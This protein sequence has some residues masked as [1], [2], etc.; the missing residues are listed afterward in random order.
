MSR[1]HVR[2]RPP[3]AKATPGALWA[4]S[5]TAGTGNSHFRA[6]A[7]DSGGNVYAAGDIIGL[8]TFGF[9]NGVTAAGTS[10]S[11]SILLVKYNS[12]GQA[13]W[14]RT[15]T[16]GTNGGYFDGVAVDS[17]G[18]VYA[19]GETFSSETYAF[20]NSV[21]AKGAGA[22]NVLLV[23][24]DPSG[25][26]QWA[27]TLV[28]GAAGQYTGV[29][30]DSTGN[31][32]VA[33]DIVG[34]ADFGNSVTA[35][36]SGVMENMIL[37]KY[38][39]S[40]TAVWARTQSLST[41]RAVFNGVAVDSAGDAFA[42][43]TTPYTDTYGFGNGVTATGTSNH[44]NSV[45]VKYDP[46][47]LAFWAKTTTAGTGWVY[48]DAVAVDASGNASMAGSTGDSGPYGFG[49][50]VTA[51]GS[52][53]GNGLVVKY[54][55]SGNALETRT[56]LTGPDT[57]EYY[58]IALAPTGGFYVGG[59]LY[60]TTPYGLGNGVT[61]TGTDLGSNVLLVKYP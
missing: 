40:G 44:K 58:G 17:T 24:Y 9:G 33:G 3:T 39:S 41:G 47:G 21:T 35:T 53:N 14:A 26:A 15:F 54:D 11:D 12:T 2:H 7:T 50:G 36:G 57:G 13:Q 31:I 38:D 59:Y 30:V 27:R 19:V 18:N 55:P 6:V 25:L 52:A 60:G 49:N 46:S 56:F 10:S 37:V 23:K 29:A 16:S 34:S 48:G 43:G 4:A 51:T 32:L 1:S 45:L 20:G 5:L 61:V 22:G 28:A 8:G 42:V